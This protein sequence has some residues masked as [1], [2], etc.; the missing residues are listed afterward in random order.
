MRIHCRVIPWLAHLVYYLSHPG[1]KGRGGGGGVKCILLTFA[2]ESAV[3][4]VV[5][6][7]MQTSITH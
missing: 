7:G 4:I 3:L 1:E 6:A 5:Y 2:T